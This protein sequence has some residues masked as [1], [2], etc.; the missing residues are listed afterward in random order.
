MW[1][2][3][4]AT[5]GTAPDDGPRVDGGD[6]GTGGGG[7]L[8]LTVRPDPGEVVVRPQGTHSSRDA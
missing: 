1:P 7:G 3:G 2:R 5:R 4:D 8:R 6:R